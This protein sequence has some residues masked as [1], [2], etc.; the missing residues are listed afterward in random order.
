MN[1]SQGRFAFLLVAISL[2]L[3]SFTAREVR[4]RRLELVGQPAWVTV[5]P[6]SLYQMRRVERALDEGQLAQTDIYLNHPH[7]AP[8]P[9]P[10]YYAQL[11]GGLLG[12]FAPAPA[13][14]PLAAGEHD[15]RHAWIETHVASLPLIF[16]V[17]ATLLAACAGRVLAG[18][19]GGAI[20]GGYHAFSAASIAY[21]NSGNGDHHA[22]VSLLAGGLLL[23]TALALRGDGLDRPRRCAGYGA[24]MGLLAGVLLGSW[25]GALMYVIEV[26]LVLGWLVV[27]HSRR[28]RAGTAPLGLA[29][30]LVTLVTVLPAV[31][32]S[33][34]TAEHPWIAIN[35]SWFHPTFLLLGAAVFVPLYFTGAESRA[36][37]VYPVLVLAGLAALG[38]FVLLSDAGPAVAVREGFRWVSRQDAF[39]AHVGESRPLLVGD[40]GGWD[41]VVKALGYGALLF[42][43]AWLAAA[44]LAFRRNALVLLPWVVSAPLLAL[45]AARQARFADALVIPMAVLLGWGLV[46]LIESLR[47]RPANPLWVPLGLLLA[48]GAN[49]AS[50]QACM[51]ARAEGQRPAHERESPAAVSVRTMCAWMRAQPQRTGADLGVLANSGWGHAI[52]WGADRPTVATNFGSYIGEDSFR[53]PA[54]FFMEEDPDRAE[55]LLVERE[56]QYVLL[57]SN[58]PDYLNVMIDIGAPE[59]RAR[60]VSPGSEQGGGRVLPAWFQTLGARLMFDGEVFYPMGPPPNPPPSRALGFLRLV[61]VAPLPDPARR[62]RS[63]SDVSPAGW[64]WERVAGAVVEA[65]GDP[66]ELL[67]VEV[68]VRFPKARRSLVF[69]DRATTG[70]DGVARLRVPYGTEELNGDGRVDRGAARWRFAGLDGE[71][72]IPEAAVTAGGVVR[73]P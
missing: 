31:L 45:Q 55:A 71:L 61:H 56:I 44:W 34:W 50:V 73:L 59:R 29:F 52:E 58:L 25:V 36:R 14:G 24:L 19:L 7:G 60:Y 8:I 10:P 39:M 9:W 72:R 5:D 23:A 48:A 16:G 32:A 18:N 28:P 27:L 41:E 42:P 13:A 57:T 12:P 65:R 22:F 49:L 40:G 62:L 33:P 54:R 11:L 67:E 53:D 64:I 21:S 37:A 70:P 15:L 43:V 68:R 2:M 1:S 66:G 6:D 38:A 20:A 4:N 51:R 63:A 26:Q 17:L 3:F 47:A 46:R 35:L 30:H 69:R